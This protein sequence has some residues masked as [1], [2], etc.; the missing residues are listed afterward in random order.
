MAWNE[1]IQV[2][3]IIKSKSFKNKRDSIL[4]IDYKTVTNVTQYNI[5]KIRVTI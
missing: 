1:I 2:I 3:K 5:V 4:P